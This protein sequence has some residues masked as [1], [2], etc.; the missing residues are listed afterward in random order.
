MLPDFA[1]TLALFLDPA[2]LALVVGGTL[3]GIVVGA[4]PGLTATLAIA[5]LLPFTFALPPVPS[6]VMLTGIFIGGIYGGSISAIAVRIPG[7]PASAMTMLDGNAMAR[8]GETEA[9]MGLATFSSFVGGSAGGVILVLFAPQLARIALEFQ[10]PEMFALVLLA[11]VAV[12]TVTADSLAKGFAATLIGMMLAT[13]GIDGLMPVPRFTF[14]VTN[15]LTGVPQ[16]AVVIGLFA[17]TELFLQAG[18]REPKSVRSNPVSFARVFSFWPYVKQV[19]WRIFAKSSLIGTLVGALPGA[20]AAMAAFL[21]Y[22]EA[23]RSSKDPD[24]FGKGNP[25][26]VV[27]PETSNN[28]MT[29]GA[30][31]PM[32][33]FGI[34]GDA[35]T[36]VILGGLMIQGII[37]GPQLFRESATLVQPLFVG[38]FISYG[39]LLVAGL[40]FLPLYA[41]IISVPRSI[42]F[43]FI[44]AIAVAAAFVAGRTS[45]AMFVAVGVGVLGYVLQRFG[46]P[47]VPVLLGLI[48]GPMLETNFR[49]SLIISRGDVSVFFTSPISAILIAASVVFA[50]YFGYVLPRRVRRKEAATR[51]EGE[52]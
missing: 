20:G 49:R 21:A 29:G 23:K 17:V 47:V 26:G 3:L 8:R 14:G 28:A 15:L 7:A 11:L 24:S 42:L 36:A 35:V 12:S 48:L 41:K 1:Q 51:S 6:I 52:P 22:S 30:L 33:A 40:A 5:L 46:Y 43:P 16:L 31:I 13:V 34:P 4:V 32:L 25:A 9:A 37:P 50:I 39:V 10:S 45:F 38:Y 2:L 27:A 44:G 18:V 19:G